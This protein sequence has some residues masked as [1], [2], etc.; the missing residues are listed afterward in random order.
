MANVH[1]RTKSGFI[2]RGGVR[3]RET[4]WFAIPPSSNTLAAASV[5]V[6][7]GSFNAAALALRPFTIVRTRGILHFRSDQTGALENYQAA[8]GMAVVYDQAVAIGVTAVPTPDTDRGSDLFFVFEEGYSQFTFISGVGVDP[9]GG[10][11]FR[12]DSKAMRKV[13]VGQDVAITAEATALS[14]G[15]TVVDGGRMLIKLH[16][17]QVVAT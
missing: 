17:R 4:A 7:S 16:Y 15:V 9:D 5:A 6:L 3:R 10:L 1:T 2:T 8:F 14:A 11:T 13:E 12:Y